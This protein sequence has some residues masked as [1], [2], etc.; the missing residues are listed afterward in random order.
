M[1][2]EDMIVYADKHKLSTAG[3]ITYY[4]L[5]EQPL[6]K[7]TSTKNSNGPYINAVFSYDHQKS[8]KHG[9]EKKKWTFPWEKWGLICYEI[10]AC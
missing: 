2:H 6:T 1:F 7:K 5:Y 3:H 4:V 8:P 9:K 10:L